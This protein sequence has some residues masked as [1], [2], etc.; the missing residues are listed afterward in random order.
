MFSLTSQLALC[1]GYGAVLEGAAAHARLCSRSTE[2]WQPF[3]T[4]SS[5]CPG[6]CWEMHLRLI[7]VRQLSGFPSLS[8]SSIALLQRHL[9]PKKSFVKQSSNCCLSGRF[10]T[11]PGICVLTLCE[12]ACGLLFQWEKKGYLQVSKLKFFLNEHSTGTCSSYSFSLSQGPSTISHYAYC[13]WLK[14]NTRYALT[15]VF[16]TV[17]WC[18]SIV[19]TEAQKDERESGQEL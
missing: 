12:C 11:H 6:L 18:L 17:V 7:L 10:L 13:W 19:D 15:H 8:P 14:E 2:L 4:R 16:I 5:A 1:E 3:V 9:A